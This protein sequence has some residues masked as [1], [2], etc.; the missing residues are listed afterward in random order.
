MRSLLLTF[1]VCLCAQETTF[2]ATV[3]VV[4]VPVTVTSPRGA[5]ADGL[6]AADFLVTDN[7]RP[8]AFQLDTADL[9]PVPLAIVIA[10]QTNDLSAAALRKINQVGSMI[11]PLITGERGAAALLGIDEEVNVLQDFTSDATEITRAF[12]RLA[13]RRARRAISLDAAARAVE[14]F[15]ARPTA[16]RRV[17][18]LIGESKD[19]GSHAELPAVLEQLQ[20]ENIQVYAATY[21]ATRTQ[22]TSKEPVRAGAPMDLFAGLGEL[23]RLG[24]EDTAAA[25][26]AHTGGRKLTFATLHTLEAIVSRVG[27]ELH[28]QYLLSFA[29]TAPEG[30]HS[31]SVQLRDPARRAVAARQ[32]YWA[33]AK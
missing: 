16:E 10:V 26:T 19:R 13:P 28:G 22:F 18:L 6:A 14:L 11:Q 12:R 33:I 29:A 27:E 5:L 31:I 1:A 17:L 3:P 20:R 30:Y 25:L 7:Q 9:S 24:K 21:S 32:G 15:R 8:V 23:V 2:R 4:L